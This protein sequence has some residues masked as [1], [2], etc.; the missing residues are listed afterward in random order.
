MAGDTKTATNDRT[1]DSYISMT[2]HDFV[3]NENLRF[4]WLLNFT[5]KRLHS[6][7]SKFQKT[8]FY[9]PTFSVLILFYSLIFITRGS[10]SE[11]ITNPSKLNPLFI[12]GFVVG[13]STAPISLCYSVALFLRHGRFPSIVY[14][15]YIIDHSFGGYIEDVIVIGN[16]FIGSLYLLARVYAGACGEI[17]SIYDTQKCN[18]QAS[19]HSIPQDQ[20]LMC[21]LIPVLSQ[22]FLQGARKSSVLVSWLISTFS[23]IYCMVYV[24]GE[25]EIYVVIY[26]MGFLLI[27]YEIE[28]HKMQSF[29]HLIM[30]IDRRHDE[31]EKEKQQLVLVI[32]NIAHDLKTPLQSFYVETDTLRDTIIQ[33][34]SNIGINQDIYDSFTS[35]RAYVEYMS[36][37]LNRSIDFTKVCSCIPLHPNL[38]TINLQDCLNWSMRC[39]A[40]LY[41]N[42]ATTTSDPASAAVNP[43][44]IDTRSSGMEYGNMARGSMSDDSDTSGT[45]RS[46]GLPLLLHTIP[47]IISEFIITDKQWFQENVLCLVSNA[48]KYAM[49]SGIQ[50]TVSL[51]SA[52]TNTLTPTTTESF[53]A[54]KCL[55]ITV[56]DSGPMLSTEIKKTIFEPL[57]QSQRVTGGVGLGLYCL[58]RRVETLGGRVGVEDRTDGQQGSAFWFT[59]PY[60][61][62]PTDTVASYPL[63]PSSANTSEGENTVSDSFVPRAGKEPIPSREYHCVE[64]G[65][66][67]RVLVVDDSMMVTK[68][69]GNALINM[70]VNV[71]IACNG[72]IGL[73]RMIDES[74]PV[75]DAVLM[76]FQMPIMDGPTAV[77]K[78]REYEELHLVNNNNRKLQKPLVIIGMSANIEAGV[79]AAGKLAGM[80]AFIPKPFRMEKFLGLIDTLFVTENLF[81][82]INN[83]RNKDIEGYK[84]GPVATEEVM[85][86]ML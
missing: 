5:D 31:D 27:L 26:T 77:K 64:S 1:S 74:L 70:G 37:S 48:V 35:I 39:V 42:T 28:R 3:V 11:V 41:L 7:F 76:D 68:V 49:G 45:C 82:D 2:T 60:N 12:A 38:E 17:T 55:R 53:E 59:I 57:R 81:I 56:I 6:K 36:M 30:A 85:V 44:N 50:V 86:V 75:I 8:Q 62:A 16:S 61:L 13:V 51:D 80:N 73:D 46:G 43:S 40:M 24:N 52:D 33:K 18:P 23:I 84:F 19:V 34:Y 25:S 79:E 65:K 10:V 83:N 22:L 78:Y 67:S 71:E 20:C 9:L 29:V 32:G 15:N 66:L 21:M 63:T 14:S 72:K 47:S 4:T 54:S 69:I 58:A